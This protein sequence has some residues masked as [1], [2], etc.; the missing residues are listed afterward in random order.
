[1]PCGDLIASASD[2][3]VKVFWFSGP[4]G[5]RVTSQFCWFMSVLLI[6]LEESSTEVTWAF[7]RGVSCGYEKLWLGNICLNPAKDRINLPYFPGVTYKPVTVFAL[8]SSYT[9]EMSIFWYFIHKIPQGVIEILSVFH[10][11]DPLLEGTPAQQ[12]KWLSS[13]NN[14]S[15]PDIN[16]VPSNYQVH[17]F[18]FAGKLFLPFDFLFF[19]FSFFF[20]FLLSVLHRISWAC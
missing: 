9:K 19:F 8:K 13:E 10:Q 7:E 14:G 16:L 1:M 20:S 3:L 11:H 6:C 18:Q 12:M 17:I 15:H 2:F 4:G 5:E